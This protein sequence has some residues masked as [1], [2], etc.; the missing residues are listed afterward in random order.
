MDK[1]KRESKIFP[2]LLAPPNSH[3]IV[4]DYIFS[5]D[6]FDFGQYIINPYASFTI[7]S[8]E[9]SMHVFDV[10][11]FFSVSDLRALLKSL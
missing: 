2:F 11:S 3:L 5:H 9:R 1:R 6:T 8:A 10:L 7:T 4:L